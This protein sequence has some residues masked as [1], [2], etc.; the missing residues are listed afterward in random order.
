MKEIIVYNITKSHEEYK[1]ERDW[2]FE[3]CSPCNFR[4][5]QQFPDN[6][7]ALSTSEREVVPVH[8]LFK[9]KESDIKGWSTPYYKDYEKVD[10][11]WVVLS[12]ELHGVVDEIVG[13]KYREKISALEESNRTYL[14]IAL[15]RKV[16]VDNFNSLPWWKRLKYLF[17]M[18]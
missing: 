12:P 2:I 5:L 7:M 13:E 17:K 1:G 3:R 11:K 6:E 8:Y 18:L 15:T 10:E 16:V 9:F 4:K 14:H